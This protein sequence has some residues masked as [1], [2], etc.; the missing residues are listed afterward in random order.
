VITD[1]ESYAKSLED[2]AKSAA[3]KLELKYAEKTIEN[4]FA[5]IPREFHDS[6]QLT[7]ADY[8]GVRL[9]KLRLTI[10]GGKFVLITVSANGTDH[11]V[12]LYHDGFGFTKPIYQPEHFS[13][14]LAEEYNSNVIKGF[15]NYWKVSGIILLLASGIGFLFE[16]L[17][18]GIISGLVLILAGFIVVSSGLTKN[19]DGDF[20]YG[21]NTPLRDSTLD[22]LRA[23]KKKQIV[24]SE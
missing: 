12:R 5:V 14:R 1:L 6:V 15:Q 20:Q 18:V 24:G 17:G 2:F 21:I 8:E 7:S 16:S 22:A 23:F 3:D 10:D 4:L 13:R 19:D 9:K 11:L